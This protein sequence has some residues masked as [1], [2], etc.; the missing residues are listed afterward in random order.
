MSEGKK[1]K[2]KFFKCK[3]KLIKT[4][5]LLFNQIKNNVEL[6]KKKVNNKKN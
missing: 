1:I 6:L 5:F 3:K 4:F 2:N